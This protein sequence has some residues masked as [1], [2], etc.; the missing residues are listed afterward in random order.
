MY[1]EGKFIKVVYFNGNF[2]NYY[3]DEIIK[4]EFSYVK[5]K[6]DGVYI[7]YYN[8]GKFVKKQ[9]TNDDGSIDTIEVLEGQ[10]IKSKGEYK[11]DKR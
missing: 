9:K 1:K 3:S 7:E 5:G 10:T 6:K 2:K 11:D 4:E 8:N